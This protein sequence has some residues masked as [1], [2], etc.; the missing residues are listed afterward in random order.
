M[1]G[2]QHV[3]ASPIFVVGSPRSGT[4]LLRVI[5]NRHPAISLCD[6]THFFY[7]VYTR[8]RAFG[9]LSDE[10]NRRRLIERYLAIHRIQRIGM[11]VPALSDELMRHGTSYATFFSTI[12]KFY[13]VAKGK[14]RHGE[15]TPHHA[16]YTQ[17]L[18]D[19]YPHCKVIHLIRDPRDVVGSLLRMPWANNSVTANARS[20]LLYTRSAE[21]ISQ[22]SNYCLVRYEDLVQNPEVE[23]KRICTFIDEAYHPAM[24]DSDSNEGK[25]EVASEWW[26]QRAKRPVTNDRVG[27]WREQLTPEQIALIE[28]IVA[29]V[30]RQFGYAPENEHASTAAKLGALGDELASAVQWRFS[31]WGRLWYYWFQ[32]TQLSQEEAWIDGRR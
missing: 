32:P 20:W 10:D 30:M 13:A 22:S 27:K 16:L 21:Q 8:R 25:Q 5:L 1:S 31:M 2:I 29:P 26:F 23:L 3:S 19:W 15:K 7:Y 14:R 17:T 18:C 12:L 28:W 4:S 24:L 9:D 6:E 11:D